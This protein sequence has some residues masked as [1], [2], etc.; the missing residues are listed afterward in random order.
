MGRWDELGRRTRQILMGAGALSVATPIGLAVALTGVDILRKRRVPDQH[1][2]PPHDPLPATVDGNELTTY[3]YGEHLFADMIEA[4]DNATDFVYLVTYIWKGDELGQQFKDAVIRAAERGV[5]VCVVFDGFANL[6]VPREFKRF[7]ESVHLLKFPTV[8]S[9][10]VVNVRRTGRD[11]RKVLVVDGT[12][13]FVGGYNIGS[14][15]VDKWRDTHMRVA[16]DAVWELQNTFVDFWNRHRKRR[17]PPL[18]DSGSP[19]WNSRILA[20]R[21]EPSR[22][23]FPVRGIYLEA[24]DRAMHRIW[25]TQGY[26][27]PDREILGG[28]LAAAERGVDIRVLM[29]EASNHVVADWVARSHYGTLLRGGVRIFLYEDVMVHAKTATVDGTWTTVGTANIDRLSLIGNY[30][31]NLEIHDRGQAAQMEEIFTRDL[32]NA[33]ELTL[34]EWEERGL[35]SRAA[36]WILEPLHPL[37]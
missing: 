8:R 36:E 21:N 18:P 33:R 26:F 16:G 13:G 20:A 28:L 17:H 7:P 15:Y 2:V 1:S 9:G 34:E 29:P 5:T 4:I 12:I 25:I 22:L 30:E 27:I 31:V 37:L 14:L 3:T 24:I 11:H 23:V 19:V 32:A 6:V 35:L 10:L